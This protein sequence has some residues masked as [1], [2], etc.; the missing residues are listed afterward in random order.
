MS[1]ER[2]MSSLSGEGPLS[3]PVR[4][5]AHVCCPRPRQSEEEGDPSLPLE[6][7]PETYAQIELVVDLAYFIYH[8]HESGAGMVGGI[9]ELEI[10]LPI[11]Y[12]FADH[13][14]HGKHIPGLAGLL[15]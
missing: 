5:D 10:I 1:D 9:V 15:V 4:F 7:T 6:P 2:K 3:L 13:G 12:R 8:V 11:Q 14:V